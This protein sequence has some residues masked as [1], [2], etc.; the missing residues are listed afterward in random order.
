[1]IKEMHMLH[2]IPGRMRI[3]LLA[4]GKVEDRTGDI[5]KAKGILYASFNPVTRNILVTYNPEILN[6]HET[7][8]LAGGFYDIFDESAAKEKADEIILRYKKGAAHND[9]SLKNI[10]VNS[11]R[12]LDKKILTATGGQADLKLLFPLSM[13]L[14]GLLL[15]L[16]A[17]RWV[18]PT[19]YSLMIFAFTAFAALNLR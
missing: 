6:E 15:L 9:S 11:L 8:S 3:K 17:D 12:R 18:N 10:L 5:K 7:I 14:W 16:L 2:S 1:M 19:W 4:G 13:L